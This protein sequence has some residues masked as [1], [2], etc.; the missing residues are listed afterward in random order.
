MKKF[1]KENFFFMLTIIFCI[2]FMLNFRII[3]VSGN[4]MD[5]TLADKEIHLAKL[6]AEIK[7]NDI[8]VANSDV[9]DCI[10]IK[11]VIGIPGDTIEIKDN[12][13]YVNG[14]ALI[15]DYIKEEMQ[16]DNL[17]P[18]TLQEHEYLACGD[19]RNHS[20]DSRL[21]GPIAEKDIIGIMIL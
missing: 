15:E 1:I 14:E 6:H 2:I 3:E 18:Y 11:R 10:I 5:F 21:L 20:T 16:T 19:N 13:L 12:V 9:L 17:G 7:R 4:S 8:I